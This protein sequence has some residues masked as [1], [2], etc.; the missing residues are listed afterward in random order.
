M[1]EKRHSRLWRVLHNPRRERRASAAGCGATRPDAVVACAPAASSCRSGCRFL[2][3]RQIGAQSLDLVCA[4]GSM[5]RE[6]IRRSSFSREGRATH[7]RG[8]RL[9]VVR[10]SACDELLGAPASV[11]HRKGMSRDLDPRARTPGDKFPPTERSIGSAW[12]EPR[13]CERRLERKGYARTSGI[14]RDPGRRH[15]QGT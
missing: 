8:L 10:S 15:H 13:P 1:D 12:P 5:G 7:Q 6:T 2:R 3:S 14:H 9:L 11:R 4:T